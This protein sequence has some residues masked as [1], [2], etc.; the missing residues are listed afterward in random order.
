MNKGKRDSGDYINKIM[1]TDSKI[2]K[3]EVK[4]EEIDNRY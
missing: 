3:E 4:T 2:L 1:H